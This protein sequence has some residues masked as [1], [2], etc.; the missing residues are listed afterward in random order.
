M[1]LIL[2]MLVYTDDDTQ[3]FY[4]LLTVYDCIHWFQ[5]QKT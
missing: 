5:Y 4:K 1:K 2:H 3:C